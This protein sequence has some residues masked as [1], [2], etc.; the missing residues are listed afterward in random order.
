MSEFESRDKTSAL[1]KSYR[2][3]G[4]TKYDPHF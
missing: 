2:K 1:E 3:H 4:S